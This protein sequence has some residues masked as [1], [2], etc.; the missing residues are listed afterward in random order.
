ME[1]QRFLPVVSRRGFLKAVGAGTVVVVA[2]ARNLFDGNLLAALQEDPDGT[3]VTR[4]IRPEDQLRLRFEFVNL[5]H[6]VANDRLVAGPSGTPLMKLT[7]ARQHVSEQPVVVGGVPGGVATAPIPH[8]V[9][10]PSRLVFEVTPPLDLSVPVLLDLA[11]H[12][13]VVPSGTGDPTSLESMIEVPADLRLAPGSDVEFAVDR[14]PI[15]AFW[16][17]TSSHFSQLHRIIL[18]APDDIELTPVHNAATDDGFDRRLPNAGDRSQ[19]VSLAATEGPATAE[20]MWLTPHGAWAD[21]AGQ[22]SSVSWSQAVRGGR[23]QFA[24]VVNRGVLMPFGH[25]A[26][27]TQTSTRLWLAD[28][29]GEIVSTMVTEEQFA[30]VGASTKTFPGPHSPSG[31]RSMPFRSVTIEQKDSLAAVKRAITWNDGA[32]SISLN[33]AWIVDYPGIPPNP[34]WAQSPIRLSYS[35]LDSAGNDPATFQQGAVFVRTESV[36]AVA[37]QLAQFYDS[38]DTWARYVR[39]ADMRNDVAWAD[40]EDPGSGIT[41][42]L[43]RQIEFGVQAI[44]GVSDAVLAAAGQLRAAPIVLRGNVQRLDPNSRPTPEQLDIDVVFSPAYLL[45]GNSPT[46]NPSRA[47]LDLVT[48]TNFPL[49]AE[50]RAVMTPEMRAEEFNQSLG[51]GPKLETGGGG[52]PGPGGLPGSGGGPGGGSSATWRPEDAFGSEAAILRGVKLQDLVAPILFDI[53]RP[54][55]DIPTFEFNELPD[56]LVSSYRWCPD[57]VSSVTAAGFIATSSTTLC[58]ELTAVV[59]LDNGV[60]ASSTVVFEVEDF[61]LVVPPG[62][63]L[64]QLDVNS[65]KAVQTSNG[66]TDLTFD[67]GG[68]R[69]GGSLSWLEPLISLLSPSG[70]GFDV[71]IDDTS[72]VA[73]LELSLPNITLGVLVIKNFAISLTGTF[74]FTG[75]DEP[76]IAIGVGSRDKP[77]TLQIMQFRGGFWCELVFSTQGLELLHIHADASAMLVQIDIV[78]AEAYCSVTVGADFKLK[79]G[80]VTFTGY[81]RLTASFNVLGVIGA[82]LEIEGRVRYEEAEEKITISGTIYWSVT[83]VFTFSGSVPIGQLTFS[84]GDGGG[85]SG[86]APLAN[87]ALPAQAAS[88]APSGGSFGDAHTI[89]SWR[90]YVEKFA[91]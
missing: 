43:T 27:W 23:D 45:M 87:R 59:G 55:I 26:I 74:P 12:A 90:T 62:V 41:T 18:N 40:E 11:R 2:D 39:R 81:L 34:L 33:D 10:S 52:V 37:A 85:P 30:V 64:I 54:G 25:E 68:W 79:D 51:I 13:L 50:A 7:L 83:A 46:L 42:L 5:V 86:F 16:P 67:I 53:A 61:T 60:D 89:D 44:T 57:S 65:M 22:W 4:L 28:A 56:R 66:N 20:R 80:N 29:D 24:T 1:Q 19:F 3:L 91:A 6:D 63:S 49:G 69:L 14:A 17:V 9:S 88:G 78:I 31:G 82:T 73:D 76:A 77:V 72:I 21:L 58:V 71:D 75:T 48:P 70:S 84:T 47:F 8:R 38:D 32:N 15:T 35:A 36:G